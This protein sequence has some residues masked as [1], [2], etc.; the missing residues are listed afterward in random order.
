[1][2]PKDRKPIFSTASLK[3]NKLLPSRVVSLSWRSCCVLMV[4]P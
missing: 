2:I 3:P 1:L 4:L